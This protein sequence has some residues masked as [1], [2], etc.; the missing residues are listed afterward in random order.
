MAKLDGWND[1]ANLSSV[2]R[3]YIPLLQKCLIPAFKV[4]YLKP[5]KCM[6]GIPNH[7]LEDLDTCYVRQE[8]QAENLYQISQCLLNS[9]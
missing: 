7:Y 5:G 6:I 1:C 8:F 2:K 9:L 4:Q 3:T